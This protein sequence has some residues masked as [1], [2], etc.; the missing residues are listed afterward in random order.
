MCNKLKQVQA[1]GGGN[2]A[3]GVQK[4]CDNL[5]NFRLDVIA[6]KLL[7]YSD[8]EVTAFLG[9]VIDSRTNRQCQNG[10]VVTADL[11]DRVSELSGSLVDGWLVYKYERGS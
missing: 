4:L 6:D 3:A 5:D 1:K 7:G 11:S 2:G 9:D 8:E 10:E